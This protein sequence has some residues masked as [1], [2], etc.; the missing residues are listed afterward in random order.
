[1]P[2]FSGAWHWEAWMAASGFGHFGL[3]ERRSLFRFREA[4]MPV[5]EIAFRLGRHR[6]TVARQSG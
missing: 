6:S 4:R 5:A 3:D 1:M 2:L